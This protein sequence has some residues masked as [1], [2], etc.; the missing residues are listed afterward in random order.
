MSTSKLI[1]HRLP[2]I[3]RLEAGENTGAPN[4]FG[5]MY[6]RFTYG[7]T[8]KD[9]SKFAFIETTVNKRV[10]LSAIVEK[11]DEVHVS[12]PLTEENKNLERYVEC[13]I[14]LYQGDK[15][16]ERKVPLFGKLLVKP[17]IDRFLGWLPEQIPE[18]I[19]VLIL[20]SAE[21]GHAKSS[22]YIL[23]AI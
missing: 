1:A 12:I 10:F 18:N 20:K 7:P 19:P 14:Q 9:G 5:K 11:W 2:L 16:F 6:A 13:G 22:Y 15:T 3:G 8:D 21:N 4:V 17:F 23:M